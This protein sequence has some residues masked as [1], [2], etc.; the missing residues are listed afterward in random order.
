M[1]GGRVGR[2]T[3]TGDSRV[4]AVRGMPCEAA[5][6]PLKDLAADVLASE[7]LDDRFPAGPRA[8]GSE[9]LDPGPFLSGAPLWEPLAAG[10][11]AEQGA[12]L[13]A[14]IVDV[15]VGAR[16]LAAWS[17]WLQLAAAAHLVCR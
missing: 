4:A 1:G 10:E 8:L 16:R 6:E 3:A 9:S 17:L 2:G 13:L 15:F 7:L 12:G 11:R 5:R 14:Q